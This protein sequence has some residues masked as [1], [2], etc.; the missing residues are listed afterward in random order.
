MYAFEGRYFE[1][2]SGDLVYKP[3]VDLYDFDIIQSIF[4]AERNIGALARLGL[5]NHP[6]KPTILR[7]S[8]VRTAYFTTKIEQNK[9]EYKEVEAL[10][11]S[12]KKN[13]LTV[14]EKAKIEVTNVFS[15]YKL[16]YDLSPEKNF[17]DMN[18]Q[19][20]ITIHSLLMQNLSGHPEGY[21][22]IPVSLKNGD[23]EITYSPPPFTDVPKYM[24]AFF[25]WL[26]TSTTGYET[27]YAEVTD[28][29]KIIHPL[30]LSA[31]THHFI[32]YIH[33]FPDGNGRTARA[34][35]TLVGLTHR[36]LSKIK[37]AYAV[38][39][40]IDKHIEDY[41][42]TLMEA[43]KGNLKPF[44]IFYLN[45]VNQSLLKVLKELQRHDKIKHI[46]EILGQS[47][48]RTMFEM[49][50]LMDDGQKLQR[51]LFDESISASKDSITKSLR[52][53]KE[54]GVIK[55]TERRGEYVVFIVDE[56]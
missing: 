34:F 30:L 41:Y 6:L 35:S 12:Y 31:V 22:K 53:L 51:N 14:K 42:D 47:Y 11:E 27:P 45:C 52:K 16:I 55:Q 17:N 54:L 28:Q 38:E 36:D 46:R 56:N 40:Y 39:E 5:K 44:V 32:G 7:N 8:M 10:F 18:E 33:P 3:N 19:T 37:D 4:E 1:E 24:H 48:A 9:L 23:D 26:F 25:K 29:N 20:L 49:I 43:T 15:T 50:A 21:R 2:M 13:R